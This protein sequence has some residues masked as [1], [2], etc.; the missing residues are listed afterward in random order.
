[1][2]FRQEQAHVSKWHT[3]L[4]VTSGVCC[5]SV[6]HAV[7]FPSAVGF[8][9]MDLKFLFVVLGNLPLALGLL[10]LTAF[11]KIFRRNPQPNNRGI[12]AKHSLEVGTTTQPQAFSLG[13]ACSI[14][15]WLG[16]WAQG[17]FPPSTDFLSVP[18]FTLLGWF[19]VYGHAN[20]TRK[21]P[22]DRG[23]RLPIDTLG[24]TGCV[25]SLLL[26]AGIGSD[27][28]DL[29]ARRAKPQTVPFSNTAP[30]QGPDVLLLS[31]DTLRAT[32]FLRDD[33]PTPHLDALRKESRWARFGRAPAPTAIPTHFAMFS[34]RNP[35]AHGYRNEFGE[36]VPQDGPEHIAETFHKAGWRT[37]GILWNTL[38]VESSI[39]SRGFEVY[40]NLAQLDPRA[41]L[42]KQCYRNTWLGLFLPNPW[43]TRILFWITQQRLHDLN[44]DIRG[45]ILG[46]SPG[47][48]TQ[49]LAVSY[50]DQ[51]AKAEHP[52]FLFLHFVD[53]HQPYMP[54]A[55]FRG[56]LRDSMDMP[57]GYE[58]SVPHTRGIAKR[59]TADLQNG[60]P[61]AQA[62][63]EYLH[64]V[65]LEEL[66]FV[67]HC[68]GKV[69]EAVR[70]HGRPTVILLTSDHGEL[71]GE[72]NLIGHAESI[73]EELLQIPFLVA[74]PGIETGEMDLVPRLE[75]VF[76]TLLKA[77]ALPISSALEG[78][79]LLQASGAEGPYLA[80]SYQEVAFYKD[81]W[82][83]RLKHSGLNAK[84]YAMEP[85]GLHK[86]E[87]GIL[88]SRNRLAEFPDLVKHLTAEA[89]KL[90]RSRFSKHPPS[91]HR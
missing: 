11:L 42:Y 15:A 71:F 41:L 68:I 69:L 87:N 72:H 65:Y 52:Y 39:L 67:D 90:Q 59:I 50:I 89:I 84:K 73:E 33:V 28:L 75:D 91:N 23:A 8:E 30:G 14:G 5:G 64:Q 66:L 36:Y 2:K 6:L 16:A 51:L 35:L 9:A 3:P 25:I 26:L 22:F 56:R 83:L 31:V 60:V 82:K 80:S 86:L 32:D 88:D 4:G 53:L 37:L 77:C 18:I 55:E 58:N 76:P 57:P 38:G 54:D 45:Q 49:E 85:V 63:T 27:T 81:E 62:A 43:D 48:P 79:S 74:G 46:P 61:Q 10:Y 70:R 47:R 29:I 44:P 40:Q 7:F 12:H 19:S 24:L 17:V 78:R 1:M 20:R 21:A 34:G 13:L